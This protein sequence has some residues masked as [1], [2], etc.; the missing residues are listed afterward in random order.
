MQQVWEVLHSSLL[1]IGI[2]QRR[3]QCV[4]DFE[5]DFVELWAVS[6]MSRVCLSLFLAL[7]RFPLSSAPCCTLSWPRCSSTRWWSRWCRPLNAA[8][9]QSMVPRQPFPVSSCSTRSTTRNARSWA[10]GGEIGVKGS[11]GLGLEVEA[12]GGQGF[13]S[14]YKGALFA[15]VDKTIVFCSPPPLS[16]VSSWSVE[17]FVQGWALPCGQL[18]FLVYPHPT[19]QLPLLLN[20]IEPCSASSILAA[21]WWGRVRRV[22]LIPHPHQKKKKL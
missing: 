4:C 13:R 17:R 5:A 3:K 1:C 6:H 11:K 18:L 14:G 20:I 21:D 10:S 9:N 7:P 12:E 22:L 2:Q 16:S 15:F 8:Q 19:P